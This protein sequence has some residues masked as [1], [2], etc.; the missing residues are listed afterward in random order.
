[1]SKN[2][3][4][5][6]IK[7]QVY[8][9]S[10]NGSG[11][12][13][14]CLE[15]LYNFM[16]ETVLD[17]EALINF[18]SSNFSN[19]MIQYGTRL[20]IGK[21]FNGDSWNQWNNAGIISMDNSYDSGYPCYNYLGN[22]DSYFNLPEQADNILE[23]LLNS[24]NKNYIESTNIY[25]PSPDAQDASSSAAGEIY[26]LYVYL[27]YDNSSYQWEYAPIS[28]AEFVSLFKDPQ[29]QEI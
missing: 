12:N 16:N 29:T 5:F 2:I 22:N 18:I 4:G 10:G 9:I 23:T 21:K 17:V 8:P 1:M 20:I 27:G 15:D 13:L 6:R 19:D 26:N 11:S 3:K 14:V 24:D 25:L 7:G 28:F